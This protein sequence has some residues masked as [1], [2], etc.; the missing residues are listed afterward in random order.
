MVNHPN[1]S[2]TFNI[3]PGAAAKL[4]KYE[5]LQAQPACVHAACKAGDP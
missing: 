3:T 2:A 1:R 4:A 5:H